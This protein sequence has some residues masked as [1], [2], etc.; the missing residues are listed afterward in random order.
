METIIGAI[1]E[2]LEVKFFHPVFLTTSA[3]F[4]KLKTFFFSDDPHFLQFC[5]ILDTIKSVLRTKDCK[6]KKKNFEL[7]FFKLGGEISLIK[8]EKYGRF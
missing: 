3:N 5:G 2:I 4:G 7:H 1:A 6:K 8:L